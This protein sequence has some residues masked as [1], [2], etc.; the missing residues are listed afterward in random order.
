MVETSISKMVNDYQQIDR[1]SQANGQKIL[2]ILEIKS[3]LPPYIK[4]IDK[5][6]NDVAP[7]FLLKIRTSIQDLFF[8]CDIPDD[9]RGLTFTI[10]DNRKDWDNEEKQY[11]TAIR[12]FPDILSEKH[13]IFLIGFD[14][15]LATLY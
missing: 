3:E 2:L 15:G 13:C 8:L 7:E 10:A 6:L 5:A 1:L 11:E 12:L 14:E 9:K 4:K